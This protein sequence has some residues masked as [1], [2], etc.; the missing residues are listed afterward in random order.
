MILQVLFFS[1]TTTKSNLRF[2]YIVSLHTKVPPE[3]NM[4]INYLKLLMVRVHT[5]YLTS[6]LHFL[7]SF[8]CFIPR[9][10]CKCVPTAISGGADISKVPRRH[11]LQ[12]MSSP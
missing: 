6:K 1:S 12:Q 2:Y 3:P 11:L 5:T 8:E 10:V 4:F 7:T 9:P